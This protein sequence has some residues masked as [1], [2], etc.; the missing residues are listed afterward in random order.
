MRTWLAL[1]L[2]PSI[3]LGV[4]SI[5]F[6]L[7]TPSCATQTRVWLHA[8]A[9]VA[10]LVV[11]VLAVLAFSE[12]SLR[13]PEP[14]SVDSD[15]GEPASARRFL[16]IVATAVAAISALVVVAMWFGLFVLSPC[17]PWP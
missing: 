6:A 11:L 15:A 2:A 16:A 17:D 10:L 1:I 7:V 9:A 12:S 13:R 8:S 14:G 3:A 4:Q 5:L